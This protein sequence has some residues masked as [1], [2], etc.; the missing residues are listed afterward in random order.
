MILLQHLVHVLEL[1]FRKTKINMDKIKY[2][3][4][5]DS[6]ETLTTDIVDSLNSE[7]EG[8]EVV[9]RKPEA[10]GKEIEQLLNLE[11]DG[12][13]MDLRLDEYSEAEYRADFRF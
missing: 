1:R 8:F 5:E 13:L 12:L 7:I 11:Y 4:L 6:D 10:F 2:L 3:F 9:L